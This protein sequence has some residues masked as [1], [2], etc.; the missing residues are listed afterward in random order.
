MCIIMHSKAHRAEKEALD[1]A[2]EAK[3]FDF[4]I[5]NIQKDD[6]VMDGK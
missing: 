4:N 5:S 1:N 2:K 6:N 3:D